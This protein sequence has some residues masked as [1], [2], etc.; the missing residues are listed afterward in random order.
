MPRPTLTNVPAFYHHY[1]NQTKEEDVNETIRNNSKTAVAFFREIP[2]EK[3]TYRYADGKWSIKEMVQHIIDADRIFSYRALCIARGEKGS[4]PGFEENDYAAASRAD[5]R[6]S[7]ELINEF[8]TLR[9]SIVQLFASFDD[10][11][12]ASVGTAN[13]NPIA[14]NAIGFIIAGHTQHHLNI[15]KERYL[16]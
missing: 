13:G 11:Q 14:A 10:E 3:W 4:L 9:N 16:A 15:L 7:A 8:E 1:I 5:N 12:L 6:T 2:E